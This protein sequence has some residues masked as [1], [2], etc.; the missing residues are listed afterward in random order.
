MMVAFAGA[1][2]SAT[3]L[4]I[5]AAFDAGAPSC[6]PTAASG[7]PWRLRLDSGTGGIDPGDAAARRRG[8]RRRCPAGA[9][10]SIRPEGSS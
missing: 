6:C 7:K 4:L 1:D 5:N 8:G 3:L 10:R 2:G 9:C